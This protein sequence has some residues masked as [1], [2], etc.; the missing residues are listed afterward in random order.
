MEVAANFGTVISI[1]A[2]WLFDDGWEE[3]EVQVAAADAVV[4]QWQR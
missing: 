3:F 2:S 1:L 4:A